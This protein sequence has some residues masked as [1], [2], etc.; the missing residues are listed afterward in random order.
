MADKREGYT[1]P[2][3]TPEEPDDMMDDGFWRRTYF[4]GHNTNLDPVIEGSKGTNPAYRSGGEADKVNRDAKGD[5]EVPMNRRGRP[6]VGHPRADSADRN[7]AR[8]RY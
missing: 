6:K 7:K 1:N 3:R 8:G 4:D 2:R 5:A